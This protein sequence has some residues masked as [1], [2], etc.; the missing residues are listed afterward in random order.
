MNTTNTSPLTQH[1]THPGLL[2]RLMQTVRP[3]FRGEVFYPPRDSA[4]FFLGECAVPG[5]EVMVSH[6]ARRFPPQP[7]SV[8]GWSSR[9]TVSGNAPRR[10][11]R[12]R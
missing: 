2:E 8:T 5:C 3:E 6:T 7:N 11:R 10:H 4:V 9:Q 12:V 1:L